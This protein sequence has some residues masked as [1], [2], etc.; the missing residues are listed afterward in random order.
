VTDNKRITDVSDKSVQIKDGEGS[1]S[2]IEYSERRRRILKGAAVVAPLMMTVASRP[3][4]G[5]G[6]RCTPS[7]WVSGN[8]SD[9]KDD[10]YSC[11]GR[12]PGYWKTNPQRWQ[13][14]GCIPGTYGGEESR[15]QSRLRKRSWGAKSGY[16]EKHNWYGTTKS[17]NSDGTP[18][19]QFSRLG[20]HRGIFTGRVYGD[21]TMMQVLWSKGHEDPYQLGAHIAAA[22]LNAK[23]IPEY[24]MTPKQVLDMYNQLER[25]GYYQPS[26]GGAPMSRQEVV[27]FIQN[28]FSH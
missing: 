23:T 4:L 28:T 14:T 22:Y 24:G 19:H 5:M 8:L 26:S 6:A 3:V 25:R 7:A 10:R 16:D 18:F 21:K 13:G 9:H 27:M 1:R 12:S 15:H 17:Y 2:H 11:G 20:R